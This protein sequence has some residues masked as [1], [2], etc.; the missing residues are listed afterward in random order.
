VGA[1]SSALWGGGKLIGGIEEWSG[2]PGKVHDS[3]SGRWMWSHRREAGQEV[4]E[5]VGLVG[6]AHRVIL[7]LTK[8]EPEPDS[9]GGGL[10]AMGSSRQR[11]KP[12][13]AWW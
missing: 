5:L 8:Y 3:N 4:E 9:A 10:F 13:V 11:T 6:E 7:V 2:L 12:D 1:V